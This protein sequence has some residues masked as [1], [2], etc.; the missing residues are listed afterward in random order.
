L[1][2]D[3]FGGDKI[4]IV[5]FFNTVNRDD[6]RMIKRGSGAGFLPETLF[7]FGI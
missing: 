7:E 1:P 5:G 3:T 4:E 6:V 2:F